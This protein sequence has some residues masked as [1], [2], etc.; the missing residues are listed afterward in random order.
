MSA[1]LIL[2]T[3]ATIHGLRSADLTGRAR[4]ARACLAR[5]EAARVMR[6]DLGMSQAEIG[7]VLKRDPSTISWMLD[8]TATEAR[9]RAFASRTRDPQESVH[10]STDPRIS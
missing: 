3:V 7:A 8:A 1:K 4:T 6:M 10:A 5:A 2:E 9:A